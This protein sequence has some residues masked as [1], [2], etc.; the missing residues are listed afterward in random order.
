LNRRDESTPRA[1]SRIP[2]TGLALA[3]LGVFA[4]ACWAL[5]T[6]PRGSLQIAIGYLFG[7]Y[8][9][10]DLLGRAAEAARRRGRAV[11]AARA[12]QPGKEVTAAEAETFGEPDDWERRE[13][14]AH[15][16]DPVRAWP[17]PL[18]GDVWPD[19]TGTED[20][21]EPAR[22]LG[23]MGPAQRDLYA[24]HGWPLPKD[25]HKPGPY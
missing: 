24:Q 11:M 12:E 6:G 5:F 16:E 15:G 21:T 3:G 2:V 7:L 13:A 18:D 23:R 14:W 9:A 1:P 22:Q 19:E 25:Q 17:R 20:L 10:A 8:V 4:L